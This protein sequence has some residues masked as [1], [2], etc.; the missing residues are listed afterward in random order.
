MV[1]QGKATIKAVK[2]E[3]RALQKA[4]EE[5]NQS[6]SACTCPILL[7]TTWADACSRP[8]PPTPTYLLSS[9]SAL[10]DRPPQMMSRKWSR[11]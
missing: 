5:Q 10:V 3:L 2:K 4:E 1:E 9:T 6:E 7:C 8:P 11:S